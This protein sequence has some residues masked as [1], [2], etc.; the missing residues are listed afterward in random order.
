MYLKKVLFLLLLL[1]YLWILW[2]RIGI[3]AFVYVCGFIYF[4][5]LEH[6]H[7]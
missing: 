5:L 6:P 3:G 4:A 2:Y 7:R 1:S